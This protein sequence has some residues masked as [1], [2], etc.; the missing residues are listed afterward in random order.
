M[1]TAPPAYEREP[2]RRQLSVEVVATGT[3]GE[4]PWARLDDTLCFPEGGGQP[5]DHGTLGQSTVLDVQRR[6][7]GIRHYLDRPV[8]TG[9][10]TLVLDWDRRFDHMQQHTAQHLLTAVALGR[11][12]W[13]TTA[14]HLGSERSD[15]ELATPA[16]S[17]GELAALEEAAAEEI[18]A[19]RKVTAR[20]V[21]REEM[22]QLPVRSRGL[23]AGHQG[24]IR[25]VEIADLDLNTCGGTHLANTAEIEALALLGTERLR[26]GVRLFWIAG[27]RLRRHLASHGQ[28]TAALGGLLSCGEDDLLAVLRQ[29]LA[30]QQEQE[31]A[32]RRLGDRLAEAEAARLAGSP[33]SFVAAHYPSDDGAFLQRL[34][35]A[36][37]ALAPQKAALLT[38]GGPQAGNFVFAAGDGVGADLS[39]I[40]PL[41]AERL[42]GR[43]GG[44][45]PLFQGRA[46]DLSG[47][48]ELAAELT[49]RLG[50]G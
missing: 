5:P 29:R 32:L 9:P 14:F 50:H 21:S 4:R 23:P 12:G 46:D 35:R 7:D 16:L 1:S 22:E 43:G 18:R 42:R 27:R 13:A 38:A 34:A 28:R 47:R 36:F 39:A 44:S 17:A 3:E 40:R 6:E 30:Q 33:G 19:A 11:F 45:G 49:A 10:A 15:I 26:G 25:L 2:Y 41:V 20:R 31:R 48:E 37:L 8:A 24:S